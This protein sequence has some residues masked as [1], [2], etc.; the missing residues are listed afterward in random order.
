MFPYLNEKDRE[1]IIEDEAVKLFD[2]PSNIPKSAIVVNKEALPKDFDGDE[3]LYLAKMKARQIFVKYV[4]L[5]SE[6][7]I[8]ISYDQRQALSDICDNGEMFI[9]YNLK[10]REVFLLF[11]DVKK[12]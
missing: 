9:K 11:E 2:F 8:N 4:K 1:T 7:E 10:K 5:Y 6:Y 3:F 12:N